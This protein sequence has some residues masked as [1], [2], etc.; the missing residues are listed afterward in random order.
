M[1]MW[2]NDMVNT[3]ENRAFILHTSVNIH[4]GKALVYV[5]PLNHTNS[6]ST[7]KK[8][9]SQPLCQFWIW[10]SCCYHLVNGEGCLLQTLGALCCSWRRG[11]RRKGWT[12]ASRSDGWATTC[13]EWHSKWWLSWY[14]ISSQFRKQNGQN[15]K[16]LTEYFG[17]FPQCFPLSFSVVHFWMISYIS[18][19]NR[20]WPFIILC[21]AVHCQW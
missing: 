1:S 17:H 18:G 6:N 7:F 16:D 10:S 19:E 12:A 5:C 21:E 11:T 15:K 2:T 9:T 3:T 8:A 13:K 4:S 20:W 14:D